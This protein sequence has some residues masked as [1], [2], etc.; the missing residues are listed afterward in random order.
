MAHEVGRQAAPQDISQIKRPPRYICL[1]KKQRIL[2]LGGYVGVP[3]PPPPTPFV[4]Q[5]SS[6]EFRRL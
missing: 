1:H 4:A 5:F 3:A 6:A 2:V